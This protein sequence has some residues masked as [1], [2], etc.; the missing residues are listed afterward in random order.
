MW[1]MFHANTNA[2]EKQTQAR[3]QESA[4][5]CPHGLSNQQKVSLDSCANRE[6]NLASHIPD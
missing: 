1:Q 6:N 3:E 2:N 4:L 5:R